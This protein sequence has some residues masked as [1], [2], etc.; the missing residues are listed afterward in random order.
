M[1]NCDLAEVMA[2]HRGRID[3]LEAHL[4][5]LQLA[6]LNEPA[7]IFADDVDKGLS[8]VEQAT[9]RDALEA[10]EKTVVVTSR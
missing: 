2:L 7:I 5:C 9:L 6:L 1:R 10:T 3:L 4:L 8:T